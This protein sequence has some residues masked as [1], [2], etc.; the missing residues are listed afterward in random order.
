[1]V[2]GKTEMS[3]IE[4]SNSVAR[5]Y[6]WP[7]TAREGAATSL[8]YEENSF[9]HVISISTLEHIGPFAKQIDAMREIFRVL[10][11]A[12]SLA[13]TFDYGLIREVAGH[14]PVRNSKC[15]KKLI[16]ATG[17][18]VLGNSDFEDLN[19]NSPE[20]REWARKHKRS[21]SRLHRFQ[22]RL[23][24]WNQWYTAF[25]LFLVK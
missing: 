16:Y 9:D 11:P 5:K 17:F 20:I 13:L 10:K 25:S 22:S 12:G 3:T 18:Q 21:Q 23:R 4:N 19:Y 6:Q 15:I 2:A 1:M 8:P 7:L 24:R 14:Y